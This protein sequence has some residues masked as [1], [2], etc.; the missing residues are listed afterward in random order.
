MGFFQN[1]FGGGR[2]VS[3]EM[4]TLISAHV[5]GFRELRKQ[6]QG[7]QMGFG[8][9][10]EERSTAPY[11]QQLL[12]N[13][14]GELAATQAG[15]SGMGL[16]RS[17]IAGSKLGEQRAQGG[18]D[19]QQMLAEAYKQNLAQGKTDEARQIQQLFN[20]G[21]AEAQ[22]QALAANQEMVKRQAQIG[23]ETDRANRESQGLSMAIGAPL[24]AFGSMMGG[25]IGAG[26]GALGGA[27]GVGTSQ[28]GFD[29]LRNLLTGGQTQA[30]PRGFTG[31]S[32]YSGTGGYR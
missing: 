17:T 25:P 5:P 27:F 13:Q 18:R 23:L 11:V 14:P 24:A 22:Q 28:G 29:A 7:Q 31:R 30:T 9:G 20:I 1:L 32:Q 16:G 15:F 12:A 6:V 2:K 19:I 10:F 4:G 3:H 26:M 8:K 21:Q